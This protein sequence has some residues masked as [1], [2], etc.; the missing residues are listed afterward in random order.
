MKE[1]T[2]INLGEY[3]NPNH[4]NIVSDVLHTYIYKYISDLSYLY[5][6]IGSN[7]STKYFGCWGT[8]QKIFHKYWY[9]ENK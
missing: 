9:V 6:Y 8:K 1:V 4:K 5:K 2:V 3:N 7:M